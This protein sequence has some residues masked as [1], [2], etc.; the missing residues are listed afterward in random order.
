[1]DC[2]L[3]WLTGLPSR[4]KPENANT[5]LPLKVPA[6][7]AGWRLREMHY[8]TMSLAHGYSHM[9]GAGNGKQPEPNN[10][11]TIDAWMQ[12]P[13]NVTQAS[14]DFRLPISAAYA[15]AGKTGYEYVGPLHAG[16]TNK[17]TVY[18]ACT[19]TA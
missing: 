5:S 15:A 10:N 16:A 2:E 12:T 7:V 11:E 6:E 9:D 3:D 19:T 14:R 13:L 4:A 17:A 8:S 1:M 18:F